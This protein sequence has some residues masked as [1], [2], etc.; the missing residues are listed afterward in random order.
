MT[1]TPSPLRAPEP[2]SEA[3]HVGSFSC[4]EPT[5]DL[6]LKR[7]ALANQ[8]NGAS[9]TFVVCREAAVQGYY[10]L[11]AGSVDHRAAPGRLRR[12]MADPIPVVVL[13]RLAV[14]ASEQGSRLGRPLVRDAVRRMRAAAPE[15]G[16]AAILVHALNERA[17]RFYLT[18]GFVESVIDESILVARLK[19]SHLREHGIEPR[20]PALVTR[21]FHNE[22]ATVQPLDPGPRWRGGHSPPPKSP[23]PTADPVGKGP[24]VIVQAVANPAPRVHGRIEVVVRGHG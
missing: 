5:L 18:C 13:A 3:H 24:P 8:T 7:R 16:I 2:L 11:A 17:K 21:V 20:S 22:A 6:W 15:I 19:D 1:E 14:T 10:A 12:N 9:R 4:G 23:R